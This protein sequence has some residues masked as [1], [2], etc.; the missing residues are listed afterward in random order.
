VF[1]QKNETIIMA[2][3]A[4]INSTEVKTMKISNFCMKFHKGHKQPLVCVVIS[5]SHY[6]AVKNNNPAYHAFGKY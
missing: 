3:N 6:P 2:N 4:A 5:N 1:L